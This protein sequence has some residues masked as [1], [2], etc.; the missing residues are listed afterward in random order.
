VLITCVQLFTSKNKN[1]NKNILLPIL[2]SQ[3]A[4]KNTYKDRNSKLIE[5]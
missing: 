1:K 4:N 3:G 5:T 2:D